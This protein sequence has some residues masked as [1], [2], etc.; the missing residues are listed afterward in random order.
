MLEA[1]DILNLFL[2][3][4]SF[5]IIKWLGYGYDFPGSVRLL[6]SELFR[7]GYGNV[8]AIIN[9]IWKRDEEYQFSEHDLDKLGLMLMSKEQNK[10]AIAIFKANLELNPGSPDALESLAEGYEADG[11]IEQ[12]VKTFRM[13]LELNPKNGYA[14]GRIKKL[15]KIKN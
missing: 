1:E 3:P 12:A 7:K 4:Q 13:V 8:T 2:G 5:W 9:E 10:Q 11:D 15:E 6:K 14:A